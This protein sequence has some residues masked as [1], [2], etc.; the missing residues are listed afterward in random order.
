[1]KKTILILLLIAW[2][3]V[4]SSRAEVMPSLE[5]GTTWRQVG[6]G[7]LGMGLGAVVGFPISMVASAYLDPWLSDEPE[8]FLGVV[9]LSLVLSV[10]FL[11]STELCARG[12]QVAYLLQE[13]GS[14][15]QGSM[16][17][18]RLAVGV[19]I[20]VMMLARVFSASV[21]DSYSDDSG[22]VVPALVTSLVASLAIP[23]AFGLLAYNK[24]R[25]SE[26][27]EVSVNLLTAPF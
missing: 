3:G 21:L 13:N 18:T 19:G 10:P 16:W 5:A 25:K 4:F 20:P 15:Y 9:S 24:S 22:L 27:V 11:I 1:M 14:E 12:I 8:S 26:P 7:T 23:S 17:K 6:Y 2:C